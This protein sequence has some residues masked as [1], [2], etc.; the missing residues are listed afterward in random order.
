MYKFEKTETS[1]A[2]KHI[3]PLYVILNEDGNEVG[4]L[5]IRYGVVSL[6]P[7]VNKEVMWGDSLSTWVFDH[8]DKKS[9][10]NIEFDKISAESESLIDEYFKEIG[11]ENNMCD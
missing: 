5:I 1:N 6:H 10:S 9:L 11:Y 4:C 2:H 8:I 7:I 3:Y